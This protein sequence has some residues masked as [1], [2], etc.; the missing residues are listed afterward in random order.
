M[1]KNKVK[2]EYDEE[3][4]FELKLTKTYA[5]IGVFSTLLSW[6]GVALLATL[7]GGILGAFWSVFLSMLS[8][9]Y[10]SST[11]K[12]INENIKIKKE[13]EEKQKESKEAEERDK[14]VEQLLDYDKI[15]DKKVEQKELKEQ[16]QIEEINSDLEI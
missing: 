11:V 7:V 8:V 14:M 2:K 5:G 9:V 6:G 12:S 1:R 10:I 16:P 15:H 13:Y 3:T 4:K